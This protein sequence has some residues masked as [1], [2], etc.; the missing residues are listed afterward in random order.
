MVIID[1]HIDGDRD[2]GHMGNKIFPIKLGFKNIS[3]Y[4]IQSLK[5]IPIPSI[6]GH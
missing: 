1:N 4:L 2:E 6:L 3:K 5:G